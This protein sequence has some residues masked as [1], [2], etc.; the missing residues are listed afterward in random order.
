MLATSVKPVL[1][2]TWRAR[3][4]G[5][6]SVMLALLH[7]AGCAVPPRAA[8][9]EIPSNP[10]RHA[11]WTVPSIRLHIVPVNGAHLPERALAASITTI[12]RHT[13]LA[14]EVHRRDS[15]TVR[16][17]NH[18]GD[19]R[20]V[21]VRAADVTEHLDDYLAARPWTFL[22]ES[23]RRAP[24]PRDPTTYQWN[25]LPGEILIAVL[26][27][28]PDGSGSTGY[29]TVAHIEPSR[30][31]LVYVVALR[32]SAIH[33][34]SGFLVNRNRLWEWTLTHEIGHILGVPARN[35]HIWFVPGLGPHCTH[36]ECVMYTGF[37]WRVL[38]SGLLHG[39]PLDF[40]RHCASELR[41]ARE[42]SLRSGHPPAP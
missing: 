34:R 39:W 30:D 17:D 21:P 11:H 31:T 27:G 40:C 25:A 28:H 16:M 24:A 8:D 2:R 5:F 12:E 35:S 33:R 9:P 4:R 32:Q 36:P 7:A 10:V 3:I 26:P 6:A 41:E 18:P 29:A 15:V 22:F 42:A 1:H 13:G 19:V 23:D 20:P 38:V 37:D 14:V